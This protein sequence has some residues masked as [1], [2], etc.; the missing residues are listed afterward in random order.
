MSIFLTNDYLNRFLSGIAVAFNQ[1]DDYT[2]LQVSNYYV[3]STKENDNSNVTH[4]RWSP[5]YNALAI[6]YDNGT[7]SV[8][9]VFG[10]LLYDS[11]ELLVYKPKKTSIIPIIN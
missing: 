3:Q 5:D 6:L 10:C 2:Q 7:F 4:M 9:S 11:R 1:P 8:F